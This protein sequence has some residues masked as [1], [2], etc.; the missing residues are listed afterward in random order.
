MEY[1]S[2][3]FVAGHRGLVGSAV[4][5]NL[6]NNGYNNLITKTRSELDLSKQDQVDWFFSSYEPEYVILAAAKV[7]G[8]VANNSCPA[9]FIKENLNVQTNV[10][11][12]CHRYKVKKLLYL[13]SSCIYPKLSAQPIK[14]EYLLSG[15]LEE[16]NEAYAIAKIAGLLMCQ[17]YARQ[18]GD[19]FI[20]AMPCNLYGPGDNFDLN[21]SHVLPALI[22]KFHDAK[23][24][25]DKVVKLWGTGNVFR[26]FLYVDDLADALIFLMNN[27]DAN[28]RDN[29]IN[30]G[31]GVDLTIRDL[32]RLIETVVGANVDIEYDITKPDGTPRKLLDVT[33]LNNLGW[34]PKTTLME[35]LKKTYNSYILM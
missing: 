16:T 6:I 28:G 5:S 14:E 31:S 12:A 13:G 26:E 21:N 10:I 22:R 24:N 8:I 2:K 15:Y 1:N 29:Y 35:G 4:V 25:K 20:A 19:N 18:Y 30:V 32:A 11:D 27:F 9:D 3:I 7:G 17:S 34:K 33:K 23:V